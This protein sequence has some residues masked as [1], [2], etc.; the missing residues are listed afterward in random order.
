MLDNRIGAQFFTI[1]NFCKT[2]EDFNTSCKK[3]SEM[4]YKVVCESMFGDVEMEDMDMGILITKN[5]TDKFI[6]EILKSLTPTQQ[7]IKIVN[8]E[9][10]D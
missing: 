3:V 1:R 7:V 10:I 6:E 2:V 4:G 8:E 9:M 5:I